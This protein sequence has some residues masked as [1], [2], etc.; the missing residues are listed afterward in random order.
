MKLILAIY[1]ICV[2]QAG[3]SWSP[4]QPSVTLKASSDI[5][6]L[7]PGCEVPYPIQECAPTHLSI[8]VTTEAKGFKAQKLIYNYSVTGGRIS[9]GG[10]NVRW[11]LSGLQPG[12]YSV[13]MKVQDRCGVSAVATKTA[14]LERCSCPLPTLP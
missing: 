3:S 11:D 12:V 2:L 6:R 9:G 1:F 7:N 14:T 5:V 10:P 8:E 13:S 4:K